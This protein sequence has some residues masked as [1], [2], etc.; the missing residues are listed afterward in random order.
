MTRRSS[1]GD[2]HRGS[3]EQRFGGAKVPV[4]HKGFTR[5]IALRGSECAG[6]EAVD[7]TRRQGHFNNSEQGQKGVAI[8]FAAREVTMAAAFQASH[9]PAALARAAPAGKAGLAAGLGKALLIGV[10]AVLIGVGIGYGLLRAFD[11]RWDE[12]GQRAADGESTMMRPGR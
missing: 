12:F 11:V 4:R 9:I 6:H 5:P 10:P 1:V 7:S 3:G 8:S 2:D